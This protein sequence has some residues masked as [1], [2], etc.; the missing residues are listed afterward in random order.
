M[1]G[2]EDLEDPKCEG[3]FARGILASDTGENAIKFKT[4]HTYYDAC[5]RD[6]FRNTPEA[7]INV[8]VA[9]NRG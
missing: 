2:F 9:F 1:M 4:N 6:Y 3:D 8:S 5:G 7:Y